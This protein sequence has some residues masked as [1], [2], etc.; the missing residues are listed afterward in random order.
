MPPT[1][2]PPGTGCPPA[3]PPRCDGAEA[4]VSHLHSINKHLTAHRRL[5]AA[6]LTGT[7][8][9]ALATEHATE[10]GEVIVESVFERFGGHTPTELLDELELSRAD[11]V[12]ALVRIA[13]LVTS[14]LRES[15]DLERILRA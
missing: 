8:I 9:A 2:A 10:L 4:K 5:D 11:L 3:S 13:P 12:A 15:G 1:P 7:A 6:P 14:V